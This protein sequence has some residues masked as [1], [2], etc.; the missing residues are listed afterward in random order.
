MRVGPDTSRQSLDTPRVAVSL[1]ASGRHLIA[2]EL[3]PAGSQSMP[4]SSPLAASVVCA[5]RAGKATYHVGEEI[6]LE[7]DF[8]G[9]ADQGLLRHERAGAGAH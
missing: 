1:D 3:A 6:P 9:R 5:S 7:L 4:P 8:R 2:S